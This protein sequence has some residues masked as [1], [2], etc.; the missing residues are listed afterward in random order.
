[1]TTRMESVAAEAMYFESG[2]AVAAVVVAAAA[3]AASGPMMVPQSNLSVA[4]HA[5]LPM[6]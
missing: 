2:S 1:M 5:G 6:Q 4:A 3:A